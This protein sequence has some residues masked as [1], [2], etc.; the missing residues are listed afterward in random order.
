MR[1]R[2]YGSKCNRDSGFEFDDGE[3]EDISRNIRIKFGDN[4][5]QY[6][7]RDVEIFGD[8][9]V[10]MSEAAQSLELGNMM[11]APTHVNIP[12]KAKLFRVLMDRKLGISWE[13]GDD[14]LILTSSLGTNQ[15]ID[16]Y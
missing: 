11:V 4:L 14:S 5:G 8:E 7:N 16:G 10:R 1:Q 12:R 13:H 2:G 15:M 9:S 3:S 6:Y